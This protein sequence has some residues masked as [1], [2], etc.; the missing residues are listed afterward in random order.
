MRLKEKVHIEIEEMQKGR[1]NNNTISNSSTTTTVKITYTNTTAKE[2]ERR[3]ERKG[4]LS[5]LNMGIGTRINTIAAA[6]VAATTPHNICAMYAVSFAPIFRALSLCPSRCVC[7][8]FLQNVE[9]QC[10]CN[11][12]IIEN[13]LFVI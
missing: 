13:V 10:L 5:I 4:D 12:V 8:F 1:R 7:A 2:R 9:I 3:K 6:A 11:I